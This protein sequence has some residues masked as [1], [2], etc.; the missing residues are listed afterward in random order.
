MA[1]GLI[2][3]AILLSEVTM[4]MVSLVQKLATAILTD[5]NGASEDTYE[6]LRM[7]LFEFGLSTPKVN[8]TNGRFYI[9]EE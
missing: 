1:G 8:A 6:Y 7:L 5:E 2:T 4:I 9:P 3:P